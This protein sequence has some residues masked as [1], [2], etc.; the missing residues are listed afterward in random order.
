MAA[1]R[2]TPKGIARRKQ[3]RATSA[4]RK[5]APADLASRQGDLEIFEV[6]RRFIQVMEGDRLLT[7]SAETRGHYL[8]VMRSL[9][10]KLSVPGKPISEIISEIMSEAA[11]LIF[12]VMQH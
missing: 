10:V 9:T 2:R 4:P 11:P 12:Q 5:G 8:T 6:H 3:V 7:V 1:K